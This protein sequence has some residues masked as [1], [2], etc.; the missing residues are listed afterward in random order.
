MNNKIMKVKAVCKLYKNS[1]VII[2][3]LGYAISVQYSHF[4]ECY[5]FLN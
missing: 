4:G 5:S 3:W 1:I 2:N